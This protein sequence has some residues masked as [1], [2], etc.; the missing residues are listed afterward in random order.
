MLDLFGDGKA[1]L[2]HL[3]GTCVLSPWT[4]AYRHVNEAVGFIRATSN[5]ACDLQGEFAVLKQ[6]GKTYRCRD[7][8]VVL[9]IAA[10]QHQ[11][12]QTVWQPLALVQLPQ[13]RD[14]LLIIRRA[15]QQVAAQ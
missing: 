8:R 1:T 4:Q 7:S 11:G 2:R 10:T 15:L 9:I 3:Q 12:G 14:G 5:L 13:E 6:F